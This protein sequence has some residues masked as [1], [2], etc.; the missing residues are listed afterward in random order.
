MSDAMKPLI[1]SA[2]E[3]PLSR[4]QAEEAFGYLFEGA[5]TPAQMG[6]FLMALRARG[7]SVSEYAAAAAVM[8]AH[9]VPV[10]APDDAMDIV[11]TGGD[12]KHT[13]NISTA[14]AFVVAGAGVPVAKHGNRNLSSKSG[15][16]DV[17]SALGINVM[18]GPEVVEQAIAEAG[19]GFMMAPMHHPAMKH[20]GPV[21]LELGCKTIFNIL[22]PL[23]NPAGVKRQLT[24][25][26][27]PDLIFPMAETLQQLGTEKAWL[28]HGSDG[29]DEIT[30][31][32]PT[33]VA[34]L[35]NGKIKSREIH[36][37]EAGLPVHNF[38]DIIG[39]T[40][41]ENAVALKALLDGAEGAYRDAV[42]LN[43]AAALIV[44]DKAGD[45]KAGVEMARE[46]IDSRKAKHALETLARITSAA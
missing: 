21:R 7:E 18:V 8:R 16:A 39:G 2:S 28:V 41:E 13:L 9:C 4:A 10:K 36:P 40:P 6:G 29:T 43:A 22:G 42:L 1:F 30:I 11:G 19:I 17:Q 12:G 44:A 34:A 31:C 5:A 38:R 14:T 45:L 26:F 23:T 33:A 27:A 20:V 3:G 24:G 25:A 32:G 35:E 37:E 46:S 15:T